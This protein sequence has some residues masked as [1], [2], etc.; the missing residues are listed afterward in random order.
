MAVVV[1]EVENL[2]RNLLLY[3]QIKDLGI[4]TILA[5]NMSDRMHSKGISID[6][7]AL[8]A[9]LHTKVVM[10]SARKGDGIETLKETILNYKEL[11]TT[12]PLNASE[13]SPEFFKKMSDTFP[14]LDL[15]QLWT[16]YSQDFKIGTVDKQAIIDKGV[17]V[18]ESELKRLQQRETIK[19]YQFINELLKKTYK[20]DTTVATDIRSRMDKILTHKVWGYVIFF[21]IMLLVFQAIFEW[22]SVPMEWIEES[23]AK[24]STYVK[25][26]MEPGKLTDLIAD[27][28]VP[29]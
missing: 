25:G 10:L 4:P 11:D 29:G 9:A 21:G 22:S 1:A 16:I 5:V 20:R 3:T 15:Y 23:F 27:G 14:E 17:S 13:I 18:S 7:M 19:R 8:E 12:I 2:K 24:L 6:V 28:I 26:V